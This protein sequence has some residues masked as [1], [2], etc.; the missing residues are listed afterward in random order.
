M[1]VALSRPRPDDAPAIAAALS[2]WAVTRWLSTPPW[3]YGLSDAQGFLA[4]GAAR[5]HAIRVGGRL[6]GMVRAEDSFGIW[7]APELQG[8]GIGRRAALLALSRRHL[9]GQGDLHTHCLL[10]NDR[11]ARLLD[12]LGFRVMGRRSLASRP[13]GRAVEADLWRLDAAEF[14][15]RHT[16]RV[17]TP[18]LRIDAVTP[19]DLPALHRIVTCPSVARMLLRF[20]PDMPPEEAAPILLEGALV[21]PLRLA[22]RHEGVAVGLVGLSGGEPP[23]LNYALDPALSGR[24][25]GREMV[26]AV[27][28]ELVARFDPPR[29]G[30]VVFQDNL[31]SCRVLEGL[32]FARAGQMSLQ[33]RGRDA[34]APAILYLREAE[35]QG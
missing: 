2:D 9:A 14:A 12:W 15:R 11:S 3:P 5:D 21:P 35:A 1:R 24:G 17:T 18:R 27:L 32:G 19:A 26:A 23:M 31:P 16:L 13:L 20:A 22:V 28:E 25:L 29:I 8:R 6:A 33:S 34:P 30:A 4:H 10:G 7:I